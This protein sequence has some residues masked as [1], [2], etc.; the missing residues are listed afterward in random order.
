MPKLS[1]AKR[2]VN[3]FLFSLGLEV[4]RVAPGADSTSASYSYGNE[5]AII[6]E[7]LAKVT[8]RHK[9]AVDIGA[10]DGEYM[11]NSYRLFKEGWTGIA[12]EWNGR[13]FAKMAYLYE[14]LSNVSLVRG[15]VT[16]DNVLHMLAACDAPKEFGYLGLDIDSYDHFVL[17]KV[18]S[19]YRPSVICTE[20]NEKIPP[21]IRFAANW[22]DDGSWGKDHFYGQSLSMLEALGKRQNYDLV[23]LEYNNAFLVAHELN[24]L[25]VL[26]AADAFRQGYVERS[27]R[28]Q[29]FP[30]NADMEPVLT[31]PEAELKPY[32]EQ[33]F[34]FKAGHFVLE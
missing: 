24:P 5:D 22:E 4:R 34:K 14:P 13:Q 16:P 1:A 25:P 9:F 29:R 21:P 28:R 32:F 6:S 19:A 12:F 15:R 31:M 30:W 23:R 20:I 3:K 27:D 18:L 33:K 7:L 2:A 10:G 26:T 11:S 8:W 17:E